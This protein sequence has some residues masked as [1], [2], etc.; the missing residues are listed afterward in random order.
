MRQIQTGQ[1]RVRHAHERFRTIIIIFLE[2]FRTITNKN[3][4]KEK[5]YYFFSICCYSGR[6]TASV[7]ISAIYDDSCDTAWR[8]TDRLTAKP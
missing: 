2:R 8:Q 7:K 6:N 3:G 5:K 4:K 1:V